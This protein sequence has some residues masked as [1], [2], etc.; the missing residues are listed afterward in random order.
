VDR[1]QQQADVIFQIGLVLKPVLDVVQ[2]PERFDTTERARI[3]AQFHVDHQQLQ[4]ALNEF[5][6]AD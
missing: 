5:C 1:K 4:N 6:K 3:R 2:Q